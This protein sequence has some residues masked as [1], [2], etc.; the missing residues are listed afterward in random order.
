MLPAVQGLAAAASRPRKEAFAGL[1]VTGSSEPD[2]R[3]SGIYD[4][5]YMEWLDILQNYLYE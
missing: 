2:S 4:A 5:K 3:L 1:E